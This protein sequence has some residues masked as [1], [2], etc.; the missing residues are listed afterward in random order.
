[1]FPLKCGN[2]LHAFSPLLDFA[3]RASSLYKEFANA[4]DTSSCKWGISIII[5]TY[6]EA[7]IFQAFPTML[8]RGF[9]RNWLLLTKE[10]DFSYLLNALGVF[11]ALKASW[12]LSQDVY[13]EGS[14]K[15][16]GAERR[17]PFWQT[18]S[19]KLLHLDLSS[20][21]WP[22]QCL[23]DQVRPWKKP[24]VGSV[25]K[26]AVLNKSILLSRSVL[27]TS[28]ASYAHQSRSG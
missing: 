25:L 24:A 4:E 18:E 9:S 28:S 26:I 20:P 13:N 21:V 2:N 11:H 3:E 19:Y 14:R 16:P 23:A 7:N 6:L 1:M 17:Q 8:S 22:N 27:S 10:A 15:L 12:G 5:F